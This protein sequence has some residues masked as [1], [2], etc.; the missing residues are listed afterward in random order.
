MHLSSQAILYYQS[1]TIPPS[2]INRRLDTR[3]CCPTNH[4]NCWYIQI[5]TSPVQIRPVQA[6]T[7]AHDALC[8]HVVRHKRP[9]PA[10]TFTYYQINAIRSGE[11]EIRHEILFFS[12]PFLYLGFMMRL[13]AYLWAYSASSNTHHPPILILKAGHTLKQ[14]SLPVDLSLWSSLVG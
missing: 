5:Q 3:C 2:A 10:L 7:I 9:Q 14:I 8:S 4:I 11:K 1:R 13:C 6:R 12:D